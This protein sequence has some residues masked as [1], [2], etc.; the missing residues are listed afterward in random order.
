MKQRKKMHEDCRGEVFSP[1]VIS[2]YP[3]KTVVLA[4]KNKPIH[5]MIEEKTVATKKENG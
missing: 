2:D 3:R 4:K 5:E 1:Q